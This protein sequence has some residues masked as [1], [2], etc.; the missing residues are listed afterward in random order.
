MPYSGSNW[1]TRLR[2]SKG[3]PADQN[4]NLEQFLTLHNPT[5]LHDPITNDPSPN[6]NPI[7]SPNPGLNRTR[8][9]TL[10]NGA[11]DSSVTMSNILSELF[12]MG[13]SQ[14]I[15]RKKGVRKQPNPRNCV[16]SIPPIATPL[17]TCTD[18]G[19]GDEEED[20]CRTDLSRFS[21]TEVTV[22]DTSVENWKFEKML[23]RRKN[24][25]KVRDK[26]CKS[27]SNVDRKK[28]K[29]SS[30]D[31]FRSDKKLKLGDVKRAVNEQGLHQNDRVE[32]FEVGQENPTQISETRFHSKLEK[33]SSSV[34]LVK[35]IPLPKKTGKSNVKCLPKST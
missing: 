3:F 34:F 14:N 17:M 8:S 35:N 16:V 4:L 27:V 23:F 28:R 21:R 13:N 31:D 2:S 24:V 26:K 25:W 9:S 11:L 22:I 10:P 30:F 6:P 29:G 19:L 32:N 15:P 18:L 5:Q 12:V 1:L 7:P 20:T 33:G